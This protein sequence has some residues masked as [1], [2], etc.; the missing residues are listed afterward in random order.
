MSTDEPGGVTKLRYED[1]TEQ[2]IGAAI[3]IVIPS[4][5][6]RASVSLW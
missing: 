3:L 4:P 5:R 6:L 1:L 2:I